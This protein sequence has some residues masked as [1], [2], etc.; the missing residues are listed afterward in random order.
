VRNYRKNISQIN[1]NFV[2]NFD[3]E[4]FTL[5]EL[6]I[7]GIDKKIPDQVFESSLTLINKIF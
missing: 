1:S 6:K 5:N 2:F 4:T 3:D 7:V